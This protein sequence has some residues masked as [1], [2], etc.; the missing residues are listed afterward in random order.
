MGKINKVWQILTA[1]GPRYTIYSGVAENARAGGQEVME[2][3]AQ[4]FAAMV[5]PVP[6][7]VQALLVEEGV[8]TE[9]ARAVEI[10]EAAGLPGPILRAIQGGLSREEARDQSKE[11]LPAAAPG[12]PF[13]TQAGLGDGEPGDFSA[14]V[15]R[16][17]AC[18][19]R[20]AR[21]A[22]RRAAG[23][24]PELFQKHLEAQAEA[25]WRLPEVR[26]EFHHNL[27]LFRNYKKSEILQKT[28]IITGRVVS[29]SGQ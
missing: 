26:K 9:R 20:G 6:D 18:G 12:A 2:L 15:R 5:A 14:A 8:Q 25:E 7:Q 28:E 13:Q 4:E 23:H 19:A 11:S 21:V 10:L 27:D 3:S 24:Y 17:L 1:E 16:E 22:V 29:C